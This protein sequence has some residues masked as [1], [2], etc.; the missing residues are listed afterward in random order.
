MDTANPTDAGAR[1][2]VR[3]VLSDEAR[4][5]S[6]VKKTP[7]CWLWTGAVDKDGYGHFHAGG[8]RHQAHRYRYEL[9]EGPLPSGTKVL[10]T[11]DNPPCVRREHLFAASQS[12]NIFDRQAKGRQAKGEGN[13]RSKLTAEQVAAIR[14]EYEPHVV[15]RPML[16]RRYGVS[17][18]VIDDILARK[19]WRHVA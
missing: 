13:G 2:P 10:H 17:A 8:K 3:R 4:F 16:A 19:T 15:T 14:R 18:A 1:G 5:W 12:L 6:R 7:T 9:A 11:C